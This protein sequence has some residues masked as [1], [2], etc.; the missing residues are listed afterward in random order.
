MKLHWLMSLLVSGAFLAGCKKEGPALNAPNGTGTPSGT[1]TVPT[2]AQTETDYQGIKSLRRDSTGLSPCAL[3]EGSDG[4]LYGETEYGIGSSSYEGLVFSL[5]KDGSGFTVLHH[6]T[7]VSRGGDGSNPQGL[8]EGSDGALY[9]TTRQGGS[10]AGVLAAAGMSEFGNGTV[11]KLN[12]DGSGYAVL[13]RFTC[14]DGD[15][16]EPWAGVI[17]GRDGAL[18]GTTL[19]DSRVATKERDTRSGPGTV[20]KLN[21]DG[22]GYKVLHTF[23]VTMADGDRPFAALLAGSDGALYGTTDAGGTG[24][25]RNGTVFKLNPDGSGYKVLHSFPDKP[26]DG[27]MP[28]TRL[29]EGRDGALY[30]TTQ[31]GGGKD[32]GTVFKLNKDGGGYTVLY[33][34]AADPHGLVTEFHDGAPTGSSVSGDGAMP[35]GL[36]QGGDGALYGTTETGGRNGRG[37]AFKLNPDGSGFTILHSFPSLVAGGSDPQEGTLIK[38]RDGA[39]YG[40][41][42]SGGADDSGEVF[43]LSISVSRPTPSKPSK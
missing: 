26:L 35:H 5:S 29:L 43:K 20:F 24:E 33:R 9:G 16:G 38:G 3:I 22:G 31:S 1:G 2:A 37:T 27:R 28:R 21:K 11:F 30:G 18:Y 7:G 6:F 41:T 25:G 14:T 19:E 4:K 23:G 40:I 17:E 8:V 42:H 12:K 34:F 10:R 13:R 39:L 32:S 36:V 15:G